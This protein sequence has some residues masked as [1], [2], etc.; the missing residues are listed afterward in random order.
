M[1]RRLVLTTQCELTIMLRGYENIEVEMRNVA[2]KLISSL[3]LVLQEIF[4]MDE[5][6]TCC[7]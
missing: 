7:G 2:R 4:M 3:C 1:N 6:L 5:G